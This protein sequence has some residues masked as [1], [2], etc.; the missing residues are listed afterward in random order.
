MSL[1]AKRVYFSDYF[2]DVWE[3]VY[4]P[5]EDSFLFAENLEVQKAETVLDMGTGCGI[6]GI[7]AAEK[8]KT[9]VAVD[10]NPFAISCARENANLN[11][12]QNKMRYLQGDLFMPL[13]GRFK[14]DVVLF[15][16]PYLPVNNAETEAW[17]ERAWAGGATGRQVI[18]RFISEIPNHLKKTGR[19]FL[20]QSTLAD[21][22][23]SLRRFAAC[24][25]STR[26]VAEYAL[27]LFEKI[28]LI[29]S[30]I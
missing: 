7:I 1:S 5:A 28:K 17:I 12:V 21:V 6:L 30:Q 8:A 18:N 20:M 23:E 15:N 4:E 9:V 19:V 26:V 3:D 14:F 11:D 24:G 2:F 29:E 25:M 27:P 10:V 22:D 16:A 13:S